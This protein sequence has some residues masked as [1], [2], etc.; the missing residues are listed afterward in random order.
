MNEKWD[1][2]FLNLAR[3]VATW[4]KDPSTGVGAVIVNASKHV[5]GMGFNGFARGVDDDPARYNDRPLKYKMIVHAEVNAIIQAGHAAKD[6]TIYV[7]PAFGHP[8][9]CHDCAKFAIQ[10]GIKAVVG[11][12]AQVSEE[13]A[14][15][16]QESL[17]LS[18]QMFREAGVEWRIVEP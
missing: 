4:S 12:R 5:V 18:G 17:D 15:R 1:R 9:I 11:Y 16:W 13:L 2:R 7:Y 6:G 8:N 3:E 14:A 10:A